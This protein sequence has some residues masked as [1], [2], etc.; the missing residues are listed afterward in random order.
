M[1]SGRC[2]NFSAINRLLCFVLV[3]S[4]FPGYILTADVTLQSI[5]IY[6]TH[7]WLKTKPTVYFCCK[8]ENKTILP[9]V[10][11]SNV[12]YKFKGEESW[13]PLTELLSKKCKRCGF[14]EQDLIPFDDVFDE[15]ELC[16][17]DFKAHNG[18]YTHVKQA[19]LNATLSCPKCHT[20]SGD[21]HVAAVKDNGGRTMPIVIIL[22]ACLAVTVLVAVGLVAA[23]KYWQKKKRQREQAQFL[24]LFEEGDDMED[25]L[26]LGDTL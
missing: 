21:A 10:K 17:D 5:E 24:K 22:L 13:Q 20:L 25:E 14:Y 23:C 16:P 9:D 8:G 7:D 11:E 26:G 15:W 4:G 6:T 18:K 3:L 19:E 12:T 1:W 2:F